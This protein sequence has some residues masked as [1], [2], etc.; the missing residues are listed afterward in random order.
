MWHGMFQAFHCD[1]ADTEDTAQRERTHMQQYHISQGTRTVVITMQGPTSW[2][3]RLYLN[4]GETASLQHWR[5]KTQQGA[6]RWA[7]KIL[8]G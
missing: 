5:G 2:A 7:Q 8:K 4:Q 3:A 1:H 6:E